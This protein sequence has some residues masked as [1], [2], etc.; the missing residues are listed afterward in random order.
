[1]SLFFEIRDLNIKLLGYQHLKDYGEAG[2]VSLADFL[3]TPE[4]TPPDPL[5]YEVLR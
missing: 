1:M 2:E 4:D 5:M 3:E